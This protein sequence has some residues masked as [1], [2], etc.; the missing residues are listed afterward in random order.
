[1]ELAKFPDASQFNFCPVQLLWLPP[2]L[3]PLSAAQYALCMRKS[4]T[5]S[6][7]PRELNLKQ[8]GGSQF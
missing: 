2:G 3:V 4:E 8:E 1:M 6:L 7:F 5:P